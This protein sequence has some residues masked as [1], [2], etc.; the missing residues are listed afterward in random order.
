MVLISN[1]ELYD[2][3]NLYHKLIIT[4]RIYAHML[5]VHTHTHADRELAREE[6]AIRTESEKKIDDDSAA[7]NLEEVNSRYYR[8]YSTTTTITAITTIT[9]L[10]PCQ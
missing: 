10:L 6:E 9:N 4:T 3:K 5:F 2:S 7:K 8:Y 1:N